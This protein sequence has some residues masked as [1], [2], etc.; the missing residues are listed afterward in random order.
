MDQAIM[1]FDD[2]TNI[3]LLDLKNITQEQL[4]EYQLEIDLSDDLGLSNTYDLSIQIKN[5]IAKEKPVSTYNP[6]AVK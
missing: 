1:S 5:S 2:K 4:K 6:W 3:I